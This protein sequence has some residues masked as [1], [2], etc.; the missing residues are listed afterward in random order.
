MVDER[1]NG[2]KDVRMAV[3]TI[4]LFVFPTP[5]VIKIPLNVAQDDKIQKTVDI[6]INPGGAGRP[7]APCDARFFRDVG[8]RAVA[9]VEVE[10]VAP[11]RGDVEISEAIVVVVADGNTHAVAGALRSVS[12]DDVF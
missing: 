2:L 1:S 12:F 7:A 9:N 5:D 10:L 4:A 11:E 8:E 6:E 3:G